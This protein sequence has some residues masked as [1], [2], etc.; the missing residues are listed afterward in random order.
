MRPG[1]T[2]ILREWSPQA[3]KADLSRPDSLVAANT[4]LRDLGLS[5]PELVAADGN[6]GLVLVEDLGGETL[7]DGAGQVPAERA[8]VAIEAL[9]EI[10]FQ[11][12]PQEVRVAEGVHRFADLAGDALAR[13]VATFADGYLPQVSGR[14]LA[15]NA[16]SELERLWWAAFERLVEAEPTWVIQPLAFADLRW[17]PDREGLRR[18]GFANV[19]ELRSGPA[20]YNLVALCQD[21]GVS[22]DLE[23]DLLHHYLAL[24]R[25]AHA[26]FD[27]D[28]FAAHFAILAA[29]GASSDLGI[30][31]TIAKRGGP[32]AD[33]RIRRRLAHLRRA[34]SHPV[35]SDLAVW[36]DKHLPKQS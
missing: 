13:D 26:H 18:V 15:T 22:A 25:A 32:A 24:R 23:A 11:P 33:A 12:R 21:P 17:L 28:T 5:A 35:L 30:A 34:L 10:H 16:R 31:A 4:A 27:G 6:R 14:L 8:L 7:I 19:D 2:A 20:S 1:W 3:D 36:Y 29:L 9:A